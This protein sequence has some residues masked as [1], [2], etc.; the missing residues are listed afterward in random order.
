MHVAA[1]GLPLVHER[2]RS[3]RTCG[4]LQPLHSC[5]T[6]P[7]H[8]Q[9]PQRAQ[10]T[11]NLSEEVLCAAINN[12]AFA[13]EAATDFQG[14]LEEVLGDSVLQVCTCPWVLTC[15]SSAQAGAPEAVPARCQQYTALS[16][17]ERPTTVGVHDEVGASLPGVEVTVVAR[18]QACRSCTRYTLEQPMQLLTCGCGQLLA[19]HHE[20]AVSIKVHHQNTQC[21]AGAGGPPVPGLPGPGQAGHGLPGWLLLWRAQ[22]GRPVP[23]A[24][25]RPHLAVG[26]GDTQHGGHAE[27]LPGRLRPCHCASLPPDVLPPRLAS[28]L[29]KNKK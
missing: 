6:S 23:A 22:R 26:T 27:R 1:K 21:H 8:A 15:R 5:H 11:Q 28:I 3:G 29:K 24:A 16:L 13:Y 18:H 17:P 20:S 7:V 19:F 9:E 14:R 4:M 2:Q 25:R 12:N 10:L